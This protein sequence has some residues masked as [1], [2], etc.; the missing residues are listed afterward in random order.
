[1]YLYQEAEKLLKEI[2]WKET[3]D[4]D[5]KLNLPKLIEDRLIQDNQEKDPDYY[6]HRPG[7]VHTTSLAKC[8]RGV[9][10]EMLGTEKT[11]E[12]D[13]R[14]LG[15][16]K[17]GNLFEDFV[18]EALGKHVIHQQREY[19]YKYKSILIVGR[20]DYTIDDDGVLRVGEN[21]SV[22]SDSF[23]MR[24]REGTLVM[25]HNQIQLETYLWFERV[26]EPYKDAKG[27]VILTND[28]TPDLIPAPEEKLTNPHGIFSYIS[29]DDCTVSGHPVQYN[30]RII[31]EVVKPAIEIVNEGYEKKDPTVAPLPALAIYS[32]A[33]NQYQKN[34][35]CTYCDYHTHC[36]GAGWLLEATNLVTQ[37][38]KELKAA[39]PAPE[40][41]AKPKISVVEVEPP[42]EELPEAIT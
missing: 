19:R 37:R 1:M 14:K 31:D 6:D 36:A 41:K 3:H 11:S 5:S 27:N 2:Y 38:N 24:Q 25:W 7:V 28:P 30:P 42:S 35:L 16:F 9:I 32:E 13:P 17:A 33:K 21:K 29:K 12:I 15:I 34:W 23:W 26:L 4:A 40:K 10:Y 20:S 39:M 22:H 8:L 18:I